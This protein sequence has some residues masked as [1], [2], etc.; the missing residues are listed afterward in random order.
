METYDSVIIGA[1]P[2]G[3]TAALYMCR[4]GVK[5][6]LV[7][8]VAPG[9]QMLNTFEIGNYPGFPE[10]LAGWRLAENFALHLEGLQLDHLTQM[11]KTITPGDKIFHIELENNTI[12]AKTVI[13]ATGA[14]PK[15]LG[16][17][18]EARLMGRGVSYCAM[19]DGMFFHGRDVAMVGGGN[20]A[21]EEALHLSNLVNRLYI[22]HRRDRFRADR[23]HQ[24]KLRLHCHN[25][26]LVLGHEVTEIHGD[27]ALTGVTVT[28]VTGGAPR[29]LVVQGLFV[30]IGIVPTADFAPAALTKN[31]GGFIKTDCEMRTNIPGLFAAGDVRDKQCRQ[32]VTAVGDGATAAYS[33]FDYLEGLE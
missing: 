17:D 15:K 21:V 3:L 30:F 27:T 1:G 2:G 22:I 33:A 12:A 25:V 23:V 31:P 8:R 6:A 26:E 16:I 10:G 14:V 28:S 32:V 20:S 9:G 4:F 29:Q 24:D 7:E 13:I 18:G 5:T 19:C 11:V